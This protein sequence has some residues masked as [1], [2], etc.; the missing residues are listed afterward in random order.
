MWH[1][2]SYP[3][4]GRACAFLCLL[5]CD[6]LDILFHL[7]N[8]CRRV[9]TAPNLLPE[10]IVWQH[11]D[12][13]QSNRPS[14]SFAARPE[15]A[16]VKYPPS[17]LHI[18]ALL[19]TS[20]SRLSWPAAAASSSHLSGTHTSKK[21]SI[22]P[23]PSIIKVSRTSLLLQA[24]SPASTFGLQ[25]PDSSKLLLVQLAIFQSIPLL[26]NTEWPE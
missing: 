22:I 9:S 11:F 19:P 8:Q 18:H 1:R 20:S 24:I 21:W 7:T 15:P 6:R 23:S 14:F 13:F 5:P 17:I 10:P 3:D 16:P 25:E 12:A 26:P 4:N 2:T